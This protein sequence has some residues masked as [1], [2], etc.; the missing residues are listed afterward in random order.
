MKP[1]A[2]PR[3]SFRRAALSLLFVGIFSLILLS[4][5]LGS[6]GLY[7]YDEGMN[8]E[9][10]REM[11]ATGRWLVP[12]FNG[13]PYFEKPPFVYWLTAVSFQIFGTSEWAG[14]LP[15]VLS[16]LVGVLALYALVRLWGDSRAAVYAALSLVTA[17]GY[18]L[19][20][21][22]I[23]LDIPLT[24]FLVVTLLAFSIAFHE[25]RRMKAAVVLA[26][27][28]MGFAVMV[29]GLIGVVIPLAIVAASRIFSRER[30][31]SNRIPWLPGIAVF[32]AIILPWHVMAEVLRPGS[33]H[34]YLWKGQILRYLSSDDA[35]D[36]SPLG[37]LAYLAMAG[38]WFFPWLLF[39]PQA[40][41]SGMKSLR[42]SAPDRDLLI[43]AFAWAGVV[44]GFFALSRARLEYYSIPA[45]P[46]LAILIGRWWTLET[47]PSKGI[48]DGFVAMLLL[49]FVGA[50]LLWLSRRIDVSF[51][52][53]LY[54]VIDENYRNSLAG[55]HLDAGA[56]SLPG[57][58]ELFPFMILVVIALFTG[59]LVGLWTNSK[60]WRREAF[61]T[62]VLTSVVLLIH[63]HHGL[64]IFEPHR[65]IAPLAKRVAAL[66]G[67]DD[68]VAVMG[69]YEKASPLGFYTQRR[70]AVVDGF[71]GDLKYG[72]LVDPSSA[73]FF[74]DDEGLQKLW[75]SGR[76][77]FLIADDPQGALH[78]PLILNP[79]YTLAAQPGRML[80]SNRP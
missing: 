18:F 22:T 20:S 64:E 48:R 77:I 27:A 37:P 74:L 57:L 10:A 30:R 67:P 66:A 32:A 68:V 56:A 1:A 43:L 15:I 19:Y 75:S 58:G 12:Y 70:V 2:A 21:R 72:R 44:I 23:M 45:L 13:V 28:G 36:V 50:G 34:F 52:N 31:S 33:L 4:F 35:L 51:I 24:A 53:R 5:G 79:S 63:V 65:S 39:L 40:V 25:C 47:L 41:F 62:V 78:D 73:P 7:D 76:R 9:I 69:P 49:G 42:G 59:G 26:C 16:G 29:K 54:A 60:G 6:P 61:A 3:A 14:R 17:F 71:D 46:A 11:T 8:A 55:K 38:V 80:Y